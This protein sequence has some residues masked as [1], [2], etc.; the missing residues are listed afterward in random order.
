[1]KSRWPTILVIIICSLLSTG[2]FV[3]TSNHVSKPV[4]PSQAVEFRH[5]N[6]DSA[7]GWYVRHFHSPDLDFDIGLGNNTERLQVGFLFWVLPIPFSED[8]TILQFEVKAD[9]QPAAGKT[10]VIDPWRIEYI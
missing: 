9:F 8:R 10:I 4:G 2:C 6:Y 5:E 3:V 7:S 1:M